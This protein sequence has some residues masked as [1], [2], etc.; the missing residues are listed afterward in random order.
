MQLAAS[1]SFGLRDRAWP[2]RARIT[3]PPHAA[4]HSFDDL[5]GVQALLLQDLMNVVKGGL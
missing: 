5:S 3:L 4:K 2:S 1:C